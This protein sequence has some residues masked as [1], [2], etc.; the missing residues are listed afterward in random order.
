MTWVKIRGQP[1]KVI[2][3]TLAEEF[4]EWVCRFNEELEGQMDQLVAV[5][6]RY[7]KS[8]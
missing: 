1:R 7:L 4:H 6:N 2:A 5:I 3:G 8:I